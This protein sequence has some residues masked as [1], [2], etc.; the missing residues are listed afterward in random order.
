MGELSS[1]RVGGSESHLRRRQVAGDED[2]FAL[3]FARIENHYFVNHGFFEWE[4]WILDN[5]DRIRH[6][7]AVIVQARDTHLPSFATSRR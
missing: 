3:A 2:K 1:T 4:S 7:P 6:I 5:I